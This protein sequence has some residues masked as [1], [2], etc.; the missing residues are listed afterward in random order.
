MLLNSP[1]LKAYQILNIPK[2]LDLELVSG[3]ADWY[4]YAK[5][6]TTALRSEIAS[7]DV[8]KDGFKTTAIPTS[9]VS[10]H[11]PRFPESN[12][13]VIDPVEFYIT[14][15]YINSFLAKDTFR[16]EFKPNK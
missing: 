2:I 4:R 8:V 3:Y 1:D 15:R 14:A 10:K 9:F 5:T 7:K 11:I 12:V 6:L 13:G 16:S